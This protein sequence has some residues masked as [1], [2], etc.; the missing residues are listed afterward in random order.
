MRISLLFLVCLISSCSSGDS[1]P[2]DPSSPNGQVNISSPTNTGTYATFRD[3]VDLSGIRSPYSGAVTWEDMSTGT[4][5]TGYA[6]SYTDLCCFFSSCWECTN[7][8][9]NA[10]VPLQEGENLIK[11]YGGGMWADSIT[12]TKTPSFRVSGTVAY[13]GTG[14]LNIKITLIDTSNASSLY[15]AYT[16]TTGFYHFALIPAGTYTLMPD[17]LCYTFTPPNFLV[18]GTNTDMNGQNFYINAKPAATISGRLT[19]GAFVSLSSATTA[20]VSSNPNGY[21]SF[22]CIPDGSYTITPSKSLWSF[23]PVS[24]NVTVTGG[25]DVPEQDF[26]SSSGH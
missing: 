19:Y 12:V 20:T 16:D 25:A 18:T 15:T 6:W 26:Q 5:G 9:W 23:N 14:Q 11:V 21:Y 13:G 2:S 22:E 3:T 7:Y 1:G 24:R 8:C 17:D 4:T 10:S